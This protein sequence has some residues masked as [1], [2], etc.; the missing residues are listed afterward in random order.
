LCA[1]G[2]WIA[3]LELFHARD[4]AFLASPLVGVWVEPDLARSRPASD[5]SGSSGS[6]GHVLGGTLP[7]IANL[8]RFERENKSHNGKFVRV[9]KTVNKGAGEREGA[10]FGPSFSFRHASRL[11]NPPNF[12]RSTDGPF[13]TNAEKL[14]EGKD[15]RQAL[16]LETE[17]LQSR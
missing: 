3:L 8:C 11:M 12:L 13:A 10:A 4:D 15:T 6:S 14:H 5:K 16:R 17:Q 7:T 1:G 9:G 2:F